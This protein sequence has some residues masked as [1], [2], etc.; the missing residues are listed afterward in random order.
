VVALAYRRLA[1]NH[2]PNMT[3][4]ESKGRAVDAAPKRVPAYLSRMN[5]RSDLEVSAEV[6]RM[7]A[8]AIN[9][10]ARWFWHG[11]EA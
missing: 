2:G 4:A 11:P 7:I 3:L 6:L 9:T 8:A 5:H 10:D 1:R